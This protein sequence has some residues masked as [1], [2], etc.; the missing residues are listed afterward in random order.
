MNEK[1]DPELLNLVANSTMKL[2]AEDLCKVQ[3]MPDGIW[4][5]LFTE[6]MDEKELIEKGY[7]PICSSTRILWVKKDE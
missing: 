2:M 7:K 1:Y 4:Q 6:G 3:P 5:R